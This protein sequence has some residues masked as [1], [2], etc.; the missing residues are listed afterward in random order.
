MKKIDGKNEKLGKQTNAKSAREFAADIRKLKN[1]VETEELN[2]D[3][4]HDWRH[5][6][7]GNVGSETW[8]AQMQEIELELEKQKTKQANK[9]KSKDIQRMEQLAGIAKPKVEALAVK[10]AKRQLK[11][12]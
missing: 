12:P 2:S 3:S 5:A 10:Q 1:E 7:V 11:K 6:R 9:T 4:K 8:N